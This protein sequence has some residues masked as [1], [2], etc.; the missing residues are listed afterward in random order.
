MSASFKF[1]LSMQKN[2]HQSIM[3]NQYPRLAGTAKDNP[4]KHGQPAETAISRQED[5]PP[6]HS[7]FVLSLKCSEV[8]QLGQINGDISL[9]F[10]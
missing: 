9:N 3:S 8:K 5:P 6:T 2:P 7:P 10:T 1:Y 4:D